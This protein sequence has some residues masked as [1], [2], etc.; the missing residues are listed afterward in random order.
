MSDYEIKNED[1]LDSLGEGV[2]TVDKSFKINF[3]N[4]AAERITGHN[5]EEVIGQYCKNVFKSNVCFSDCPIAL[6]LSSKKNIYDFESKIQTV[7]QNNIPIKLN[8]AV[9]HNDDEEPI[10]GVIS[11]REISD[12]ERIKQDLKKNSQFHGIIGKSKP[13][14]EIF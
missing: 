13:M 7:T 5:K 3:F 9:L 2:F 8:A 11:F 6:V 10:G 12:L 4:K 1:I 14:R